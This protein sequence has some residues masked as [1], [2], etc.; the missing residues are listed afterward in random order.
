VVEERSEVVDLEG[1]DVPP[2]LPYQE[3]GLCG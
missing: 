3:S 2:P 1:E